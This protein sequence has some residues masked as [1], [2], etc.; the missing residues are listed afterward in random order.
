MVKP[1]PHTT[2][3]G[4][5]YPCLQSSTRCLIV[6]FEGLVRC[7]RVGALTFCFGFTFGRNVQSFDP[8]SGLCPDRSLRVHS[9]L[10]LEV[11]GFCNR[12]RKDLKV[13]I[14]IEVFGDGCQSSH[15]E[16]PDNNW[17]LQH[18]LCE[19]TSFCIFT[20]KFFVDVYVCT[21]G[22]VDII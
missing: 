17:H 8:R 10:P 22:S 1:G 11:I 7:P 16:L 15:N 9:N 12:D 2:G 3:I 5:H 21:V 6:C 13:L 18:Y 20:V 14:T 19:P 4:N